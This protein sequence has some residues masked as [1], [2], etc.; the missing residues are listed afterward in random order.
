MKVKTHYDEHAD[1]WVLR[2][3]DDNGG[4]V[5][6]GGMVDEEIAGIV[7]DILNGAMCLAV[8]RELCELNDISQTPEM[9][10]INRIVGGARLRAYMRH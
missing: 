9:I 6:I 7:C 8:E 2:L 3:H 5:G 4:F 10:C 1:E